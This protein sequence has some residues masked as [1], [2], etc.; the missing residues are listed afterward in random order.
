[1]SNLNDIINQQREEIAQLRTQLA[2]A[3]E[4][5]KELEQD[6]LEEIENRDSREEWLD[7]LSSEISRYFCVDIGEHS[8]ANNPWLEA[9][10]AIPEGTLNK[11]AIEKKVEALDWLRS[12]TSIDMHMAIAMN[13]YAEQ[14][15]KEQE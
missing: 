5:V 15:R 13:L 10:E 9:F 12:N 7:K 1:M 4:R 11:F 14:L 3:N 8:S 2:K 6:V